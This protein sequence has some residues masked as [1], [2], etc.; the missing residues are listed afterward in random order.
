MTD[1]RPGSDD[2]TDEHPAYTWPPNPPPQAPPQQPGPGGPGHHRADQ[3]V[4]PQQQWPQQWPQQ[5]WPQQQWPQ[6]Q[7]PGTWQQPGWS[8]GPRY[9][10]SGL[11]I[12]G[13]LA[14]IV[15]G[16]LLAIVFGAALVAFDVFARLGPDLGV[17][18][19]ARVE[20]VRLII[21]A[22]LVAALVQVV[23]GIAA[24]AH[25]EWGRVLG[26]V[27]AALGTLAG[28]FAVAGAMAVPTP[29]AIFFAASFAGAYALA[30][31]GLI[32]GSAHFKR[33]Y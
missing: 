28:V 19:A 8:R 11:A 27:F 20:T 16:V 4:R 12:A 21:I 32:A 30:L 3:Q 22:I 29:E 9:G 18:I 5:Q 7:W 17:D 33:R 14:L 13:A 2:E 23:A 1:R 24:L 6:Q 10:T 25:R 26:T 15:V 31:F